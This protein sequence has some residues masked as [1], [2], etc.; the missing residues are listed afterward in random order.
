MR[1]TKNL[2][3]TFLWVVLIAPLA[4]HPSESHALAVTYDG[5]SPEYTA[6]F[7]GYV[8]GFY[9][10]TVDGQKILG[11]CDDYQTHIKSSWEAN[12]YTYEDILDGK[13]TWDTGIYNIIG[14]LFM[15]AS[16]NM[17]NDTQLAAI[18]AAIWKVTYNNLDLSHFGTAQD[19]YYEAIGQTG[20]TGWYGHM[21]VL[22]PN[23]DRFSQEMLVQTPVPEPATLL[24]FGTGLA[25]LAGLSRKKLLNK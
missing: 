16:D 7:N 15:K 3:W 21:N 19:L 12:F 24:L 18:N 14:Y 10:L 4:W 6:N 9:N 17:D 25:G 1:L 11:M 2:M 13:G 20:Y 23:P 5:Y 22:T 8:A